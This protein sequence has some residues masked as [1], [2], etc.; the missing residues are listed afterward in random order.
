ME[1]GNGRERSKFLAEH[2][3]ETFFIV[4]EEGKEVKNYTINFFL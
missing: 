1:D 4:P 3:I 2:N